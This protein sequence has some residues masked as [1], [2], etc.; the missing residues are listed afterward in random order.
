[1]DE[2]MSHLLAELRLVF[3]AMADPHAFHAPY[4]PQNEHLL[5]LLESRNFAAAEEFLLRYLDTAEGQL[6]A[7]LG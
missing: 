5:G 6:L 3:H 4:L 2:T 7:S 1:M